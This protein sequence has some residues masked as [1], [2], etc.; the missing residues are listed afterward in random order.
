M[1]ALTFAAEITKASAWPT[2]VVLIA[3]MI[4]K[5]V[6]ELLPFLRTLKYKGIELEFSRELAQLKSDA[7]ENE[8]ASSQKP[9]PAS[10]S[11]QNQRLL[12]LAS[13]STRAAVLEA[14]AE[15]ESVAVAVASA[16]SNDVFKNHLAL[17]SYLLQCKVISEKQLAVFNRLRALRNMAAQAIDLNLSETEART[18]VELASAL[19]AHIRGK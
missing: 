16:M 3:L 8:S 2:A 9:E 7:S 4:R 17:G 6:T 15:L 12:K 1:D 19:A 13:I 18:Y 5:P 10:S 11:A 14:W